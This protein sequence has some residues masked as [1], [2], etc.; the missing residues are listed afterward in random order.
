LC[1]R[2]KDKFIEEILEEGFEVGVGLEVGR[3]F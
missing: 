3:S 1:F 2:I